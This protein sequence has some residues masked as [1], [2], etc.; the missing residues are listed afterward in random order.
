MKRAELFL[1]LAA[2]GLLAILPACGTTTAAPAAD[3]AVVAIDAADANP[4]ETAIA[5][6]ADAAASVDPLAWPVDAAGPYKCGFRIIP[7]TYTLPGGLG[8]RKADIHIWYPASAATNTH[9]KYLDSFEDPTACT[10]AP[11]APSPYPAGYPLLVHSHGDHGYAGNS[12]VLM[13]YMASHGW[14]AVAP[15]HVG[16]TLFDTPTPRPLILSLQRPLDMRKTIDTL[17][18]LPASDELAGKIDFSRIGLS[19]HSYGTYTTWA[20]AGAKWDANVL[21]KHCKDGEFP[22]CSPELNAAVLGDLADPRIKTFVALAG[23]GGDVFGKGGYNAVKKHVLQMNG[24]LDDAGETPLY[25]AVTAVDL[26]WVDVKDGCHQ[27]FALGNSWYGDPACKALPDAEGFKIVQTWLLAW[28]RAEVLDD[29][30]QAVVDIVTGKV[31]VSPRVSFK[32]KK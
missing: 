9:P 20:V 7:L 24:T 10:G 21:A 19:G 27:L 14:L 23:N 30:T 17:E 15:T 32:H 13:C 22:D 12:A 6:A 28:L 2:L 29:K 5:D 16:N 26:T 25:A 3:D 8:E 1:A 31:A 4:A 11:L 18:K